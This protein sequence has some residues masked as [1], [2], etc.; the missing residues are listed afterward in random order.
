M[1]F[2]LGEIGDAIDGTAAFLGAATVACKSAYDKYDKTQDRSSLVED[3]Q[4]ALC[5]LESII[6]YGVP[7]EMSK[8]IEECEQNDRAFYYPKMYVWKTSAETMKE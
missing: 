7:E 6:K 1:S 3:L 2:I 5:A 4:I 8:Y